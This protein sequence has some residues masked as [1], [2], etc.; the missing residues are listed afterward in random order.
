MFVNLPASDVNFIAE[1]CRLDWVQLSGRETWDYCK[2]IH[3]PIIKTIHISPKTTTETILAEI[4]H[5]YRQL[6]RER[7]VFLL[8]TQAKNTH[9][10][11]GQIFNWQIA[12]E[13]SRQYPV[14]I[15]GGL[16]PDNV[17]LLIKE[18]NPWGVDV[19]SGVETEGQKDINKIK[20]FIKKAR[21]ES[22]APPFRE[23]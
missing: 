4:K 8:D 17:G 6:S 9:G 16:T 15:A 11:T 3:K 22:Q 12:K 14:M 21:G 13:I 2:D 1:A 19:S 20:D 10:G 18:V 23:K 7:L 5:G